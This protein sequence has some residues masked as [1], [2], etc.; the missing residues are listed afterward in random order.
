M[1]EKCVRF[2]FKGLGQIF[3]YRPKPPTLMTKQPF[4]FLLRVHSS[5]FVCKDKRDKICPSLPSPDVTRF[6]GWGVEN[7]R[8]K[9]D[10]WLA[11][12]IICLPVRQ[13]P[14]PEAAITLF[15]KERQLARVGRDK[16]RERWF[17][18]F[19]QHRRQ[20]RDQRWGPVQEIR[21]DLSRG[22]SNKDQAW[23]LREEQ[24][25]KQENNLQN[26]PQSP[27]PLLLGQFEARS[28]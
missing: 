22:L 20:T 18:N 27:W 14:K 6:G 1:K 15:E 5:H 21:S 17:P 25:G 16:E 2:F 10:L 8:V 24:T 9:A 23:L 11:K 3:D 19:W 28:C 4:W 12:G 13:T 7:G 26:K